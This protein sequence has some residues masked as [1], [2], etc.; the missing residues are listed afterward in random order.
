MNKIHYTKES[1]GKLVANR[2][3]QI[4]S[5][6]KKDADYYRQTSPTLADKFLQLPIPSVD[7]ILN[8]IEFEPCSLYLPVAETFVKGISVDRWEGWLEYPNIFF[9]D[10]Y[11]PGSAWKQ[12]EKIDEIGVEVMEEM[13]TGNYC[14]AWYINKESGTEE[15][16][17]LEIAAKRDYWLYPSVQE[18]EKALDEAIA[19]ELEGCDQ[20]DHEYLRG[21]MLEKAQDHAIYLKNGMVA[22]IL[23][24]IDEAIEI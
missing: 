20:E 11:F 9:P 10:E 14:T 15:E 16:K 3:E 6:L 21:E 22:F 12:F 17:R 18:Y 4:K 13:A 23:L 24:P 2:L 8:K 5:Q 19:G 7:E 1:F